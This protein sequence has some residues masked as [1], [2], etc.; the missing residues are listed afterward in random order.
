M[1]TFTE[2][3]DRI[4]TDRATVTSMFEG[5]RAGHAAG[6]P[7]YEAQFVEAFRFVR[8]IQAGRRPMWQLQEALSTSDFQHLF[9]DVLQRQLLPTYQEWTPTWSA[10]ARRSTVPDFRPARRFA[11]DGAEGRLPKVPERSE[12]TEA[13]L[14]DSADSI[15]VTKFGRRVD[16]SWETIVND[17]LDS[18]RTLPDRLARG[19][20][21]TE[22]YTTTELYVGASGPNSALYGT[23]GSSSNVI[24]GNPALDIA[25]LQAGMTQ[26]SNLVDE[27]GEPIVVDAVTLVVPPSLEI[28]ARNILNAI[29]IDVTGTAGGTEDQ[30]VRAQNWMRNRVSLVVNPYITQIAD[31]NGPTSW[32]LFANPSTGRP[33]LEKAFLAGYETPSLWRKLA[34][35][36]PVGGGGQPME[37]FDTDSIAWRIRHVQGDAR[38][39]TTGGWRSTVASNGTG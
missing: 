13:P 1:P 32:F 8:D 36:V 31:T 3:V 34:N 10:V 17:D 26:L 29:H 24:D 12:Y 19:A 21:R 6:N 14:V 38:L 30:T 39:V 33:A 9:G 2:T 11:L 7:A 28:T 23:Y 25:G 15:Q 22:D 4:D 5:V 27:D 37:D 18:F 16:L 35:A 20:R